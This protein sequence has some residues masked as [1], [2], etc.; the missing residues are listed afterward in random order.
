MAEKSSAARAALFLILN[1]LF[2]AMAMI[3]ADALF[4]EKPWGADLAP[5]MA[6]GWVIFN[7]LLTKVLMR[8]NPRIED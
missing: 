5:W 4:G 7:G 3:F 8:R 6:V 1:A 2:W